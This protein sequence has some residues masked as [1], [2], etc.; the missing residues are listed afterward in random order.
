MICH[1]SPVLGVVSCAPAGRATATAISAYVN[2]RTREAALGV[3]RVNVM[4]PLYLCTSLLPHRAGISPTS[5]LARYLSFHAPARPPGRGSNQATE[6]R[7]PRQPR[8]AESGFRPSRSAQSPTQRA[9]F[10]RERADRVLP[11]G[12]R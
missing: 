4:S 8:A 5:F 3:G 1:A 10:G 6:G 12:R 9:L 2:E 11:R 7:L